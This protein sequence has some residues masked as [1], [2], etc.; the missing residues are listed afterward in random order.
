[1]CIRDRNNIEYIDENGD[2]N[3]I[4]LGDLVSS[5]TDDN[6]NADTHQIAT[7]TGGDG[8]VTLINETVTELTFDPAADEITYVDENG[9]ANVVSLSGL[10]SSQ[11]DLNDGHLIGEHTS[12]NGTVTRIEETVTSL[13]FDTNTNQIVY[14]CLLY[15]SPSPRD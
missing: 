8:T 3:T 4:D 5:V 1:M 15:T 11:T 10:L 12:G 2:T 6:T 14:T 9:V 7:H 13:I